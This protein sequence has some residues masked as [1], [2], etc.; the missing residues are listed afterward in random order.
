MLRRWGV[1]STEDF[2]IMVYALIERGE[3]RNSPEDSF[4][5]FRGVFDFDEAFAPP[6]AI[7]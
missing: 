1:R 6:A 7:V 5:D 3:M 2:G 4:E